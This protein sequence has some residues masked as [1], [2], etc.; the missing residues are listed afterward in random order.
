MASKTKKVELNGTAVGENVAMRMEGT[1]LIIEVDTAYRGALSGSGKTK[2]VC[3]TLGN[4][5]PPFADAPAGMKVGL[6]AYV[7]PN[8]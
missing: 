4:V 8:A 2:R 5:A 7:P 6:N 1:K 3:S